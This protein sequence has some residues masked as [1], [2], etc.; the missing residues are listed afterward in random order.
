[1]SEYGGELMR[2]VLAASAVA[3]RQGETA[4]CMEPLVIESSGR[5]RNGN[6]NHGEERI[7]MLHKRVPFVYEGG[8][9][10]A[11]LR[12]VIPVILRGD[13]DALRNDQRGFGATYELSE[14]KMSVG[15]PKVTVTVAAGHFADTDVV[16][17]PAALPVIMR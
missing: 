16:E 15:Y 10:Y 7:C 12:L 4:T 9:P 3:Q 2:R 17:L 13:V 8:E 6:G 11:C 1:M 5:D 14:I